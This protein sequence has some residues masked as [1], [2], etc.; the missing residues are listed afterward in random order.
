MNDRPSQQYLREL[1][2]I[3]TIRGENVQAYS[4]RGV[5]VKPHAS[6]TGRRVPDDCTVAA[7]TFNENSALPKALYASWFLPH[8]RT[9]CRR[10]YTLGNHGGI[11]GRVSWYGAEIISRRRIIGRRTLIARGLFD[12]QRVRHGSQTTAMRSPLYFV[13]V[14]ASLLG[15]G[16][17]PA[18]HWVDT[19]VTMPQ[20]TEY[21]NVP[22][23][24]FVRPR[25]GSSM[26]SVLTPDAFS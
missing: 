21:Y 5:S 15:A 2:H 22:N 16:A 19:W 4:E 3:T 11:H 23:P 14:A 20:L 1:C 18:G 8:L 13:A 12:A 7:V 6:S 9:Q 17:V 26:L 24:P 25:M 10:T